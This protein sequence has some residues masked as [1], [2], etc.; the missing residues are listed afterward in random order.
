MIWLKCGYL[1]VS[2]FTG[3]TMIDKIKKHLKSTWIGHI[4]LLPHRFIY[5][6]TASNVIFKIR[7]I[8]FWTFRSYEIGAGNYETKEENQLELCATISVVSKC[9]IS[10]ILK[11]RD[12][13]NNDINIKKIVREAIISSEE[14]Y[15]HDTPKNYGRRL[16]FYL[17]V[18][19]LKPGL[20]V[21][22]GVDRGLGALLI[23][24]ALE[25]NISEGYPGEYLGIEIESG[26]NSFFFHRGEI[27]TG[28]ITYGDS[29]V[30]LRNLRKPVDLFIHE[31]ISKKEHI[32]EQLNIINDKI[33]IAGVI[34]LP[35][36][37]PEVF[38]FASANKW[39]LLTHQDKPLNHWYD[40]SR[41]T[42]L[43]RG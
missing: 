11:F 30:S 19:A 41:N 39:N 32:I 25:R 26:K 37:T 15:F 18:R 33:S 36:S 17:L 3:S 43:Y 21:E 28:C 24:K 4:L 16:K 20:V 38:E 34:T 2:P 9:Q 42:F 35:W 5:A 31:T 29:I 1:A 40:G 22:A 14:R 8:F 13:I 27:T 7:R 6:I 10:E 23:N 12:E